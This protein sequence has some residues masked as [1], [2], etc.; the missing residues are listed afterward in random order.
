V[1]A[2][3]Q[4]CARSPVVPPDRELN[5]GEVERLWNT[6]RATLAKVNACLQRLVCQYQDVRQGIGRVDGAGCDDKPAQVETTI[7]RRPLNH[8]KLSKG[9]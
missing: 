6:D 1:P 2:D 5:A 3:V 4:A 8:L 7:R 9:R